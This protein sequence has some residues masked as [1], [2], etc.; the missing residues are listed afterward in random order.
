MT[1]TNQHQLEITCGYPYCPEKNNIS[2]PGSFR[3]SVEP[4]LSFE[5]DYVPRLPLGCDSEGNSDTSKSLVLGKGDKDA[6]WFCLKCFEDLWDGVHVVAFENERHDDEGLVE[7]RLLR[8][9]EKN[10]RFALPEP[11]DR[12]PDLK[13]PSLYT[14]L[15]KCLRAEDREHRPDTGYYALSPVEE[16]AFC[17]WK[18]VHCHAYIRDNSTNR[19]RMSDWSWPEPE[20][21]RFHEDENGV[22]EAYMGEYEENLLAAMTIG[23]KRIVELDPADLKGRKLSHAMD[24]VDAQLQKFHRED[25][26]EDP[27]P[28]PVNKGDKTINRLSRRF[29]ALMSA[30]GNDDGDSDDEGKPKMVFTLPRIDSRPPTPGTLAAVKKDLA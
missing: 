1:R 19:A 18:A 26:W 7:E 8:R 24:L 11:C 23:S 13:V 27:G 12:R 10:S 20:P 5:L 2:S 30:Q 3:I 21:V 16:K 25:G 9:K 17:K 6:S 22:G 29:S 28:V 15:V 4:I 14:D